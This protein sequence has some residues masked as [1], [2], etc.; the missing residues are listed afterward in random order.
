MKMGSARKKIDWILMDIFDIQKGKG[1]N[2]G[3]KQ[4]EIEKGRKR[5]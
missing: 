5:I 2:G 1:E 4:T 3:D